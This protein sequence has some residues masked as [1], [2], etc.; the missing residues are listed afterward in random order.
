MDQQHLYIKETMH[1]PSI[2]KKKNRDILWN[3]V[4][5]EVNDLQTPFSQNVIVNID[6]ILKVQPGFYK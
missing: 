6:K 2:Q 3:P 5:T 1:T 4:A